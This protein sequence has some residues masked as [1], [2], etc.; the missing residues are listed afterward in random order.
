MLYKPWQYKDT[1]LLLPTNSVPSTR[2]YPAGTGAVGEGR[3]KEAMPTSYFA[4]KG[5]E[6][7]SSAPEEPG[8]S[9]RKPHDICEITHVYR[10]KGEF[11]GAWNKSR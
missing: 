5:C 10:D 1:L 3:R 6:P 4:M 7:S 2:S 11:P 9:S 8:P